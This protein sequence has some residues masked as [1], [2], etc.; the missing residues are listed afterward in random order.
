MSGRS[1][2]DVQTLYQ[3]PLLLRAALKVGCEY[4]YESVPDGQS[5]KDG[6]RNSQ[7]HRNKGKSLLL[8]PNCDYGFG[9]PIL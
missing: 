4:R 2:P 6:A 8:Q 1:D 5:T 3:Q 9:T 7:I